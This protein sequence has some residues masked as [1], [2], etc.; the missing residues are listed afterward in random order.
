MGRLLRSQFGLNVALDFECEALCEALNTTLTASTMAS[1][2]TNGLYGALLTTLHCA[3]PFLQSFKYFP[4]WDDSLGVISGDVQDAVTR[5]FGRS[6]SFVD[7]LRPAEQWPITTEL[8]RSTIPIGAATPFTLA[9]VSEGALLFD[10]LQC[11][12]EK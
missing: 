3:L 6:E 2:S 7:H 11:A 10:D 12:L 5:L 4:F 9:M 1:S 8:E